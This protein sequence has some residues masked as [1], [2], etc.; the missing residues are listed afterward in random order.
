MFVCLCVLCVY[1][2]LGSV[3]FYAVLCE[4]LNKLHTNSPDLHPN[5]LGE[6]GRVCV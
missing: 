4:F 3:M 1:K 5:S 6:S 2:V